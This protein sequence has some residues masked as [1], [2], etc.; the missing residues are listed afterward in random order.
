MECRE[1]NT[2]VNST[3]FAFHLIQ[4]GETGYQLPDRPLG[5]Y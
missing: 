3:K 5:N 1:N 2:T 4:A